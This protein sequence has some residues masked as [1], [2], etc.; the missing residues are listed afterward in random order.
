MRKSRYLYFNP[1]RQD[2]RRRAIKFNNFIVSTLRI[3]NEEYAPE[4]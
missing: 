3:C 2:K 4:K 1:V